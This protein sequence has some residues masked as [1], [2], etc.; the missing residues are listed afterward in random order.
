MK[1]MTNPGV[2]PGLAASQAAVQSATLKG[3]FNS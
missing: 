2:E 1:S 3:Q